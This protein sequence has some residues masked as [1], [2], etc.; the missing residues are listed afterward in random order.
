MGMTSRW[1]PLAACLLACVSARAELGG[2]PQAG[3]AAV[4]SSAGWRQWQWLQPD[5]TRIDEFSGADGT[6]FA[7]RWQGPVKPDLQA[8]LGPRFQAFLARAQRPRGPG[9]MQVAAQDFIVS[10]GGHMGA[11]QGAAW[12][13][14]RLPAGFDPASTQ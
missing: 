14:S 12:M 5:G 7:V 8:L 11:F 10:S 9:A 2:A 4:A 3:A 1:I 13:P 6:V